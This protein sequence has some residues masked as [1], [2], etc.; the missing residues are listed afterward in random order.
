MRVTSSTYYKQ[1]A[2]TVQNLKSEYNKSSQQVASGRKYD[3][4]KESPLDYYAGKKLDN[5]YTDALTKD[6]MIDDVINRM[7]QQETA[8]RSL[9]KEMDSVN[10]HY[11]TLANSTAEGLKSTVDTVYQQI[12]ESQQT[13]VNDMNAQYENFYVMGGND[14][15]TVPFTMSEDGM[16]LTY[17]HRFAGEDNV[18]HIEMQYNYNAADGTGSYTY[19]SYQTDA[20]GAAVA[21]SEK[22]GDDAVGVMMRAMREQGRMS[23]GYGNIQNRD[24]LVD[25]YTGGLNMITGLS[26]DA[27]RTMS[28]T[29]AV[30]AIKKGMENSPIGLNSRAI[31]AVNEYNV[32]F[33]TS[34]DKGDSE[35]RGIM[36]D[37]LTA[38]IDEWDD[39]MVRVSDTFRRI[40]IT[41][42]TLSS[43]QSRLQQAEDTYQKEYKD[44]LGIDEVDAI[45]KMYADQYAYNAALQVG[46]KIIQN[47]LFDYVSG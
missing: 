37:V 44:H 41:T 31:G 11:L 10:K 17:N 1:Y 47:S 42:S 6:V 13:M 34:A 20:S 21:G 25:T 18:T 16:T 36:S 2:Q 32:S 45:T 4:A 9:H 5:L 30:N 26:S 14:S 46:S 35:K 39:S 24:T 43:V 27:L 23:L 33:G 15:T 28:D 7:E 40:G 8:A 3:S 29:D 22:T 38:V 19:K 12:L